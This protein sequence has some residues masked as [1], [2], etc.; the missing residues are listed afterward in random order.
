MMLVCFVV[1]AVNARAQTISIPDGTLN[2]VPHADGYAAAIATTEGIDAQKFSVQVHG[3]VIGMGY[4]SESFFEIGLMPRSV[5]DPSAGAWNAGV[6][7]VNWSAYGFGLSLAADNVGGPFAYPLN[8]PSNAK[9]WDFTITLAPNGSDGG[10]ATLEV[11]G[12]TLQGDTSPLAYA[13]DYSDSV[14]VMQLTS[15]HL[16]ESISF[17]NVYVATLY[18][19][20]D[21]NR[22]GLVNLSDLQ[23]LG[24]NWQ[25]ATATWDTGD[26]TGDGIVN[27][28]DLQIIG[29]NWG[30]GTLPDLA[31][32]DALQL[33]GL[34]GPGV[35]EPAVLILMGP[36]VTL[37]P[38]RRGSIT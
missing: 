37:I 5:W 20:G 32:D 17:V 33:A 29:D 1:L 9:P 15:N 31:F 21:A 12:Q 18:Q 16:D 11:A 19:A 35:P 7:V 10:S 2:V 4:P 27:L 23:I 34:P 38:R 3:T 13:G 25:S 26:F 14:L 8:P 24:D 28:A 36:I 6:Y 22:D 30:Y